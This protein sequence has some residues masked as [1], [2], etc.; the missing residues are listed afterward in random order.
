VVALIAIFI[1]FEADAGD[2]RIAFVTSTSGLTDLSTWD[3]AG[4]ATGLA[5]ADTICRVRAA[6]AGLKSPENFVAW[7]SSSEDDAYCRIHGLSGKKDEMCGQAELPVAAGPW[8]RTDGYP[9][10]PEISRLL[11]P[12]SLVFAP[13]VLDEN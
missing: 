5:A 7:I 6:S 9:F 10:A 11:S 13:L 1:A 4:G 12:E 2:H 8:V 3:E